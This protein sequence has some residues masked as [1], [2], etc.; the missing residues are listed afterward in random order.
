MGG[1]KLSFCLTILF[2]STCV[3]FAD[4]SVPVFIWPRQSEG[5]PVFAFNVINKDSFAEIA[6]PYITANKPVI[7]YLAD[8]L[9]TSDIGSR[10]ENKVTCFAKFSTI[11]KL[12]LPSVEQPD[13]ALFSLYEER[14]IIHTYI[15]QT[16]ELNEAI[17]DGSSKLYIVNLPPKHDEQTPAEYMKQLD[18]ILE[19]Q[20]AKF[21]SI[22][23]LFFTGSN[24]EVQPE[25]VSRKVRSAQPAEDAKATENKQNGPQ[26]TPTFFKHANLLVYYT[27]LTE[28]VK[29]EEHNIEITELKVDT[30]SDTNL[31]VELKGDKTTIG[32]DLVKISGYWGIAKG[33]HNGNDLSGQSLIGAPL[34]FSYHCSPS[35]TFKVS[36]GSETSAVTIRGL[37][38]EP[39]FGSGDPIGRY[40]AAQ[41]CVGF[42]SAGIWAGLFVVIML[43]AILTIGISWIMDIRTM[44]RFDDPKGKH[45]N[46]RKHVFYLPFFNAILFF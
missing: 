25:I 5:K 7:V 30:Q 38:L 10:D 22:A 46:E 40:S 11:P 4:A 2:A 18:R 14:D 12:Y 20:S 41:D 37:Q 24:G 1:V 23:T 39:K 9:T 15:R 6:K 16:G 26:L 21:S 17:E 45:S 3:L 44:D 33:T 36:N 19:S 43:L 32:L 27:S 28:K 35:I 42:T 34:G 31:H 8:I 29:Q 13:Q